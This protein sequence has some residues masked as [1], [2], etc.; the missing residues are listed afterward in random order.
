M[1]KVSTY[2]RESYY[3]LMEK[4]TWPTWSQLQQ[5]T[6]IVL[7]STLLIMLMVWLM[8]TLSNQVLQLI[9]SFFKS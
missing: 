2:I 1:N 7:V 3:E 6:A 4:V 5:S 9:Y 8:D